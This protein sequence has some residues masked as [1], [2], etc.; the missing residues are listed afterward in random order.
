MTEGARS[1]TLRRTNPDQMME[2]A[3]KGMHA[4]LMGLCGA[5]LVFALLAGS[6]IGPVVLVFAGCF[7]MM[8]IMMRMMGGGQGGGHGDH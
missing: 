4:M 8:W 2:D 5:I 1:P 7:L 3:M 6:S